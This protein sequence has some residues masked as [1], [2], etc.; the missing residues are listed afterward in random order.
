[1]TVFHCFYK[2]WV[3]PVFYPDKGHKMILLF[4]IM[5]RLSK[6]GN[7]L[8][9]PYFFKVFNRYR[10]GNSAV[11]KLLT[12]DIHNLRYERHGSRGTDPIKTVVVFSTIVVIYGFPC[13]NV[14]AYNIKIHR[15]ALISVKIEHI[16]FQRN[17]TVSKIRIVDISGF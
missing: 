6:N 14:S 2:F 13:F 12:I 17:F 10:V 9:I 4:L 16:V 11:K 3:F 7:I 15:I 5:F 1:M 8:I